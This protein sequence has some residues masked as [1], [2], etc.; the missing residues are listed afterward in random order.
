MLITPALKT[1]QLLYTFLDRFYAFFLND[2]PATRH[3]SYNYIHLDLLKSAICWI[4]DVSLHRS[5]ISF[6]F[7]ALN[8]SFS[9]LSCSRHFD[10]HPYGSVALLSVNQICSHS[11]LL[12]TSSKKY[13]QSRHYD[14]HRV[15]PEENSVHNHCEIFPVFLIFLH[16][17]ALSNAVCKDTYFLRQPLLGSLSW[18]FFRH[19]NRRGFSCVPYF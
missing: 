2:W 8:F 12:F 5:W 17:L 9:K 6:M 16:F 13:G 15:D 3:Y 1:S 19:V 14:S 7:C 18:A 10:L 11:G 4:K